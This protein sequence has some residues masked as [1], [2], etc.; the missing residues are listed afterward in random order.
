[1]RCNARQAACYPQ[2]SSDLQSPA[3]FADSSKL[4]AGKRSLVLA[5]SAM[6]R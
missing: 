5:L 6:R 4:A 2:D 3:N 1:M